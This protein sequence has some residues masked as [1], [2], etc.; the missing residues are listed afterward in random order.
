LLIVFVNRI[1]SLKMSVKQLVAAGKYQE[2]VV[3]LEEAP[4]LTLLLT[5]EEFGNLP[6]FQ[7]LLEQGS[8]KLIAWLIRTL[9]K[10]DG[11]AL[12]VQVSLAVLEVVLQTAQRREIDLAEQHDFQCAVDH[13]VCNQMTVDCGKDKTEVVAQYFQ[14]LLANGLNPNMYIEDEDK[15][16]FFYALHNRNYRFVDMILATPGFVVDRQ[17]LDQVNEEAAAFD[18]VRETLI[19]RINPQQATNKRSRYTLDD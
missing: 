9:T 17:L 7:L 4:H 12:S 6:F 10:H 16:L 18:R 1:N 19:A 11:S 14:V 5:H 13:L 2:A 3:Y 15:P 8:P